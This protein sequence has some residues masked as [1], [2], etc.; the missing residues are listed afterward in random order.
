[1]RHFLIAAIALLFLTTT[2]LAWADNKVMDTSD[3]HT[4]DPIFSPV[5]DS[6]IRAYISEISQDSIGSYIK[7]LVSFK[8]RFM[9]ADNRRQIA[10]WIADKFRSFGYEHVVLDSFQNTVEFPLRSGKHNSTWQYNVS[11]CL[12]GHQEPSVSCVLGAHFDCVTT[13]PESDPYVLSPGADNNATGVAVTFEIA[14]VLR[15]NRFS[16]EN[17]IEFVAFGSEEFMTMFIDGTSGANNYVER[18]RQLGKSIKMMIDNNQIGYAPDTAHWKLDFQNYPGAEWMT[19]LA[20]AICENYTRIIPV[21]T[22]DH[23]LYSDARYFH[24]AGIPAIFFEEYLFNPHNFTDK[25]IPENCNMGYC[26][27]VANISCG[28]LVYLNSGTQ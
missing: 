28:M 27:E 16:P 14:R 4:A 1:M 20:H 13:G 12:T 3:S 19:D 23:M 8:T 2:P 11:T 9:L 15:Q 7:Q 24:E 6:L 21:D 18:Q 17:T 10:S 22:N 5:Q 26:T 25:D